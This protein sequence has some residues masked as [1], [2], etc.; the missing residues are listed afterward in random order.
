MQ[1]LPCAACMG[2]RTPSSRLMRSVVGS[3]SA[4]SLP[5]PR[6]FAFDPVADTRE[7]SRRQAG[8]LSG[9]WDSHVHLFPDS[10]YAALHRWFDANA[11][12]ITFR[13]DAEKAIDA[14][15][16]AGSTR[17]S[18]L[19]FAHK[20]GVARY[21]NQYL[22]D[23][24]RAHH[25]IVGVGAVLPGEPDDLAIVDEAIQIHG[26]RGIKI[27]CHVSKLAID[28]ERVIA[29]LARCAQL[30]VPAVVHA[31]RE[32][33]SS[34]YGVDTRQ[35][36]SAERTRTVLRRVPDLKLVVPHLGADEFD[37]YFE[38]LGEFEGLYLD[39]AMA[40]ADY[41][42]QQPDLKRVETHCDR[43]LF[44]TDFPIIP[45]AIDRE[46]RVLA[47]SVLSDSAFT[48]V[49]RGNAERFWLDG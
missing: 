25:G 20:P 31:G 10:F 9:V 11:W 17:L 8:L 48:A 4:I 13:G 15:H 2:D 44:G 16:K 23:M 28:D 41:F 46:I 35:L 37:Q 39:T 1:I 7:N 32:P 38:L 24:A 19:V 3:H 6:E 42:A 33:S 14:L 26:L 12:S 5:A 40:C 36:C 47:R 30:R 29:V 21:L 27:H 45:Y 22:G 34:A 43:V 18:A 49:A